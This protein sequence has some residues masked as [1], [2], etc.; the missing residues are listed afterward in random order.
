MKKIKISE[1]PLCSSL[2]G[3]Y[4]I[5]TDKDNRS[6]K[7]SLEFIK[8]Q[9]GTAVE[10][11]GKATEKADTAAKNA[12]DATAS[13]NKATEA[14]NT[15]ASNASKAAD[16]A[17]EASDAAVEATL[18]ANKAIVAANEAT[19]KAD[20]ATDNALVATDDANAAKKAAGEATEAAKQATEE[21]RKLAA[22]LVPTA[23]TVAS[24]PRLTKGNVQPVYIKATLSPDGVARNLLF[25]SDNRA[26]TVTQDG[27]L[28]IIGTGRST[29]QVIPTL[30]TGLAKT[31]LVE[32]GEPTLRL[33]SRAALRLTG[34]GAMRL[35]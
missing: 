18:A 26:V 8:E 20:K 2:T 16:T 14:A 23:L 1:L 10:S 3:L 13:A 15:A 4:T 25:L 35:N 5:G 27:C 21:M 17:K 32:V 7:V 24:V 30:N 9:T 6:V 22:S 29:V 34:A 28:S 19:A 31:L 33:S 12:D 11:A